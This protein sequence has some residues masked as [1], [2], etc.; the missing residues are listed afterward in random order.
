MTEAYR[1]MAERLGAVLAPVGEEWW[2]YKQAHPETEMY[3]P[4][5]EAC[6]RDR[7]QAGC[8]NPAAGNS[9]A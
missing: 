1:E 6:L 7:F 3:A 8:G 9:G 2:Q 5:G 4:D